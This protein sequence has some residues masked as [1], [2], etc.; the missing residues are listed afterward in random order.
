MTKTETEKRL[1][2]AEG[3]EYSALAHRPKSQRLDTSVDSAGIA[4]SIRDDAA[5]QR[6]TIQSRL[7]KDREEKLEKH[8]DYKFNQK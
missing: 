1:K 5:M 8:K 2:F 4:Y 3:S 7:A 6:P